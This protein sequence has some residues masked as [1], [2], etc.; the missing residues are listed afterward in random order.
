MVV[1]AP[2]ELAVDRRHHRAHHGEAAQRIRRNA[3][4]R[5]RVLAFQRPALATCDYVMRPRQTRKLHLEGAELSA[6]TFCTIPREFSSFR[7]PTRGTDAAVP[8]G[9]ADRP[10]IQGTRE[11]L[12]KP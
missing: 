9:V 10:R 5:I 6:R 12:E 11:R 8:G 3:R 7:R 1:S 4:V 2:I